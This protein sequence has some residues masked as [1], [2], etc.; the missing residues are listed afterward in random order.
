MPS[1]VAVH[2]ISFR[3]KAGAIFVT[4]CCAV[5][6]FIVGFI[7]HSWAVK[8]QGRQGLWEECICSAVQ[9]RDGKS[10]RLRGHKPQRYHCRACGVL[11][12]PH[13]IVC[14]FFAFISQASKCHF[15]ADLQV[16]H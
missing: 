4:L 9:S 6:S 15:V 13:A 3:G 8:D 1:N 2:T 7:T 12:R 16:T 10:V 11:P 5:V 14:Y